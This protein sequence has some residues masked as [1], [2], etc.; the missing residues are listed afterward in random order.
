MSIAV[1]IELH[2]HSNYPDCTCPRGW[3]GGPL[4]GR[5]D[6]ACPWHRPDREGDPITEQWH[7]LERCPELRHIGRAWSG[8]EHEADCP[9]PKSACG[10]VIEQLADPGCPHHPSAAKTMRQRHAAHRCP[11]PHPRP[12][13]PQL[14]PRQ[15]ADRRIRALARLRE[16]EERQAAAL[17]R[18]RQLLRT[19]QDRLTQL[20]DRLTR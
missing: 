10:L 13:L 1:P 14:T 9:C 17:E 11:G 15:Q 20:A 16:Q 18:T 12:L 3:C 2:A 6:A 8:N 4:G 7:P 5:A 19:E